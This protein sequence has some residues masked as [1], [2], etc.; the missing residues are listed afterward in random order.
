MDVEMSGCTLCVAVASLSLPARPSLSYALPCLGHTVSSRYDPRET[1]FELAV[2][3]IRLT[4][5]RPARDAVPLAAVDQW[6][7]FTQL[8]S[9]WPSMV[10]WMTS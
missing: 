5:S 1:P 3:A 10:L 9:S 6:V 8:Q 7:D 2:G 4:W